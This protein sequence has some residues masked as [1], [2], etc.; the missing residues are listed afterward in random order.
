MVVDTDIARLWQTSHITHHQHH[1][2]ATQHG[3][4]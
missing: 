1:L 4:L 3:L 2:L